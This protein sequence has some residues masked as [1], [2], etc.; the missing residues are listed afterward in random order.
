MNGGRCWGTQHLG[1]TALQGFAG[2]GETGENVSRG[3]S[4]RF[5]TADESDSRRAN[6]QRNGFSN[7]SHLRVG[8]SAQ[9]ANESR[10]RNGFHLK[11]IRSGGFGKAIG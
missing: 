5:W 10:L 6:T 8:D 4:Q 9:A 3:D 2:E 7:L 11:R 1:H